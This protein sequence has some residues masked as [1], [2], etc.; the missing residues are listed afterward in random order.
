MASTLLFSSTRT[1]NDDTLTVDGGTLTSDG[2]TDSTA[3]S[4]A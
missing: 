1:T 3:Q 4:P 2:S